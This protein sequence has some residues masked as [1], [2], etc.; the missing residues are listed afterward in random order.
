MKE[1][2]LQ[3]VWKFQLFNNTRLYTVDGEDVCVKFLGKHNFNSGPDFLEASVKIGDTLWFGSVEIHVNASDWVKHN[4]HKDSVYNNVVL[5]VVY[6]N[7]KEILNQNGQTIPIV[8]IADN[9]VQEH[10]EHFKHFISGKTQI[11]CEGQLRDIHSVKINS[12]LDRLSYRRLER[13]AENILSLL[14]S[15]K[16]DWEEVTHRTLFRYFGMKVNGDAMFELASRTPINLLRKSENKEALLFGQ[17]GLLDDQDDPYSSDL[18]KEY[19]YLKNKWSL[20]SMSVTNWKYSK[21]RPPNFPT[22][23]IAQ[24]ASLYK[25]NISVF[26]LVKKKANLEELTSCFTVVSSDYWSK[27]YMFGKES[28]EKH[29]N[30]GKETIK[31]ILINVIIPISFAY[32]KLMSDAT[33][34]NYAIHL[35]DNIGVES[36]S[37]ISFWRQQGINPQSA[38]YSQALIE[39]YT[40][41]CQKKACL[42]CGIGF[43]ILKPDSR[44]EMIKL[45]YTK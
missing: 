42:N 14:D 12:W 43:E 4:H 29:R 30:L 7:D 39:L 27:H 17:A 18:R 37:I 2:Y 19:S 16:G 3:Y 1:D 5:H 45:A 22:V 35:L 25:E 24:I 6:N 33:F 40:E 38:H 44:K 9:I 31:N 41:M 13:K 26:N 28:N 21:L 20:N 11:T 36:N 10:Y 32:G 34:T 8:E 15:T 23:R